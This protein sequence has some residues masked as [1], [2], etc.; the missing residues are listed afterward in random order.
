[1]RHMYLIW[2]N[3]KTLMGTPPQYLFSWIV[4]GKNAVGVGQQKPVHAEIP[5]YSQKT[6][7]PGKGWGR[8]TDF[9]LS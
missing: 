1:M 7:V 6:V 2:K 9:I 3:Q 5:A 8:K 4:P